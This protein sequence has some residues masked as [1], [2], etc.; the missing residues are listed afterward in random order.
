MAIK[1]T[2]SALE[3]GIVE[4]VGLA[5]FVVAVGSGGAMRGRTFVAEFEYHPLT[6]TSN[7]GRGRDCK[8]V[9][10]QPDGA[11]ARQGQSPSTS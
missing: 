9:E 1:H 7:H 2:I 4:G 11:R 5:P 3:S 8:T 10:S 6:Y